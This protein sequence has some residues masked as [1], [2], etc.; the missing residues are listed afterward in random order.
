MGEVLVQQI[1][2]VFS[3]TSLGLS[4]LVAIRLF[5]TA[6]RTRGVPEIAMGT[7]QGLIVG[8]IALYAHLQQIAATAEPTKL[9]DL[10]VV[11]NLLIAVG[12][13]ALAIGIWRI[14]RPG[15][16]WAGV[17]CG[18]LAAWVIGGWAWTSTGDVLPTTVAAT[19]A[20]LFFVAG[21]SAVYLWGG[22]EGIR[23]HRMLKRRVE[24]GLG[25]PVVAHQILMWG[26]FSLTMGTLAITSLTAGFLLRDAYSTWAPAVFIT[27][28][29]SLVAS[30]CLWLGFFPP[31]AYKR[32]ILP[33]STIDPS[34]SAA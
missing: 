22:F 7:Y 32:L 31:A 2:V 28:T 33:R 3:L 11:A 15:Q 24:L 9:F 5:V 20:N 6:A 8:A 12:A 23:F 27:P 19:G 16:K 21:R 14:Y 13:A 26:L 18:V 1:A 34:G 30:I 25:D 4:I 29:L 10:A 17:V